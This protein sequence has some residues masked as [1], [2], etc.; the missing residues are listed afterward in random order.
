[1]LEASSLSLG[2]RSHRVELALGAL[3]GSAAAAPLLPRRLLLSPPLLLLV[4]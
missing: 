4:E 2:D 1:M 3:L